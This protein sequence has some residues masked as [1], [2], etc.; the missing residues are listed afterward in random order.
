MEGMEEGE[1]GRK[2]EGRK[3][4][5]KPDRPIQ[6]SFKIFILENKISI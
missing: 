1:D 3:K 6:I 4:K 2:K 5:N